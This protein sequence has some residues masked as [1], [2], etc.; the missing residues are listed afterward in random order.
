MIL[1]W[2]KMEVILSVFTAFFVVFFFSFFFFFLSLPLTP[3]P[4]PPTLPTPSFN[5][6]EKDSVIGLPILAL[7]ISR[8]QN[9]RYLFARQWSTRKRNS[10]P[11]PDGIRSIENSARSRLPIKF[12]G[13][14]H[15]HRALGWLV[16]QHSAHSWHSIRERTDRGVVLITVASIRLH[17]CTP[18]DIVWSGWFFATHIASVNEDYLYTLSLSL[19][20][21]YF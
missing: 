13:G 5:Y 1:I 3:R 6:V 12:L 8:Y 20:P 21:S 15:T 11:D 4:Y 17:R 9:H 14:Q 2:I 7:R 18:Q 19:F 16:G 10:P